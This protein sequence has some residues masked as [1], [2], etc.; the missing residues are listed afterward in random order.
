MGLKFIIVEEYEGRCREAENENEA[1][2]QINDLL[3]DLG[4]SGIESPEQ[5]IRIYEIKAEWDFQTSVKLIE[6][7][8]KKGKTNGNVKK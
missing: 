6:P 7:K 3:V 1:T 2:E 8:M 5:Y 4:W